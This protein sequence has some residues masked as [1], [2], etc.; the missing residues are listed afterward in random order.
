[1]PTVSF[2][3]YRDAGD[4]NYLCLSGSCVGPNTGNAFVTKP[5]GSTNGYSTQG[6]GP[7]SVAYRI[8]S[9]TQIGLDDRQGAGADN[10]YNDLIVVI[11][12]GNAQF[13]SN[14]MYVYYD[15]PVISGF[16]ASP[17]PQTSGN[18]GIPNYN[19]TLSWSGSSALPLTSITIT[20]GSYSASV[21]NPSTSGNFGVTN[22]PQ[23]VAGG[24]VA[25]RSYTI[26]MCHELAC[27][28]ESVTVGVTND[29]TP[30]NTW[31]TE[32][33]G[34]DPNTEYAKLL[35]TFAGIDMIT[36]VECPTSGV[37]FSSGVNGS[38]ANPQYFNNGDPVYIKM[39]TL[40]FNTDLSGLP[41]NQTFG[42]TNTKTVSVTIGSLDA[43]DVDYVTRPPNIGETFDFDG[44]SGEYPYEDIDLINNTPTEFVETQTLNMDDIDVDVEVKTDDPN[45]QIKINNLDWTY[46]G[47]I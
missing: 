39:I 25:N 43:F 45:V 21:S 36:K 34:L 4:Q 22:L 11:T 32:F 31:Q 41:P 13:R 23:S 2:Q 17:N 6:S 1:M 20:S 40:P 42:K 44:E 5:A 14:G 38:Y 47:E 37:F 8:D 26:Q 24:S 9:P 12:S 29:N 16:N 10:D 15:P 7:G 18:D 3:L 46:I 27:D 35:G 33:T 30:S 19:T 28:L